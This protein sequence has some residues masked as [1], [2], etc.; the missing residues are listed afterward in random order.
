[1][2]NFRTF[3]NAGYVF[4]IAETGGGCQALKC[5]TDFGFVL[6]T[7]ADDPMPPVEGEDFVVGFYDHNGDHYDDVPQYIEGGCRT[8]PAGTTDEEVEA[9]IDKVGASIKVW[10]KEFFSA[11]GFSYEYPGFW[12]LHGESAYVSV[13]DGMGVLSLQMM[14]DDG[15]Y[16]EG[17]Q[18]ASLDEAV[19]LAKA[20]LLAREDREN[21]EAEQQDKA[22]RRIA[23]RDDARL[24]P[25]L[26]EQTQTLRG[27]MADAAERQ[28]MPPR[29]SAESDPNRPAMIITDAQTGRQT[30][31]PLFAYGEVRAALT[32]LFSE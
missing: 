21:Y 31:V 1:M 5:E 8:F 24:N 19:R 14:T 4:E 11:H 20:M 9:F 10:Q 7:V 2:K 13:S 27:E 25:E 29:F 6:I 28:P 22:E 30:T 12:C 15:V 16:L 3:A 26:R 23:T 17:A 32:E 18:A